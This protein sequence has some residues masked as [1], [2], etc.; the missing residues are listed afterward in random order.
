MTERYRMDYLHHRELLNLDWKKK[1]PISEI[2]T[3]LQGEGKY[4]GI[5]H[6]LIRVTGCKLRCQFSNSFCDTPYASWKP[7][8][9][10]YTFNDIA[11]FYE[12]HSHIKHTMITGGGPTLHPE[13]L[14]M[15]CL[16]AKRKGH[17]ITIETE[18]SEFV[19]TVGDFVSLSPKLSNSTPQ[20][21]TWMEYANREVTEK[22]K[23]QHEKWRCNY[24]DMKKLIDNHPD[25]QMKPVI[26]NEEDLKE[27][28]ELQK[29]LNVPNNKVWLMPEGLVEEQLNER[30]KWLMELC[31][32]LGYNFSDRLHIITYGDVRGV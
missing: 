20:P 11:E 22:D 8:K 15:L 5:P 3:C 18:G 1:I 12:T 19:Q 23:Q 13:V 31:T 4:I 32:A 7:E 17:Y 25:Y 9:G 21:G 2:Y 16:I 30:R 28:K 29:I 26:S 27:V 14:Q 6:I 24:D 10:K